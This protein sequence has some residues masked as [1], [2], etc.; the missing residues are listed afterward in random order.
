MSAAP[1]LLE[2]LTAP[3]TP[4]L[5]WIARASGLLAYVALWLSTVFGALLASRGAGGLLAPHA[6]LELHTRWAL[7]AVLA[8]AV[9]VLAVVG[10]AASQV[11]PLVTVAPLGA[12][13]TPPGL[14]QGV[15]FGVLAL[16]G[17]TLIGG[18]T[19]LLRKLKR[20]TWR[21]IHAAA[22]GVFALAMAHGLTAGSESSLPLV[23]ARTSPPAPSCSPPSSSA[24]C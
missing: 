22:F 10:D 6:V 23:R 16:W 20:S 11:S 5:W 13:L 12:A 8:T 7:A 17:M 15:A 24:P 18:S 4:A 14:R 3:D 21:A 19:A 9:H 1:P 2:A